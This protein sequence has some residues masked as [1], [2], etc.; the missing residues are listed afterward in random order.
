MNNKRHLKSKN[1][2]YDAFRPRHDTGAIVMEK[3]SIIEQDLEKTLKHVLTIT[4]G[5]ITKKVIK[6]IH[7]FV[8]AK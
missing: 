7:L 2:L 6:S 8:A 5:N 3:Q 1:I 4:T